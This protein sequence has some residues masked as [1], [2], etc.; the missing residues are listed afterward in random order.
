MATHEHASDT[1]PHGFWERSETSKLELNSLYMSPAFCL[2]YCL[3]TM[4]IVIIV[5]I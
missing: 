1:C 4:C 2:Q 5:V 3:E